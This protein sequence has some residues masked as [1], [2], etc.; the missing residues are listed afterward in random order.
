MVSDE[1]NPSSLAL[2]AGSNL[3]AP[4]SE[5]S[6]AGNGTGNSFQFVC[7]RESEVACVFSITLEVSGNS[8][9]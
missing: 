7:Q 4:L 3:G 6:T 9:P 1:E 2:T 8:T 5:S